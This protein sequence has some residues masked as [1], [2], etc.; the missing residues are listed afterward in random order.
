ME[1]RTWRVRARA[2]RLGRRSI[3]AEARMGHP[4]LAS[5]R[6]IRRFSRTLAHAPTATRTMTGPALLHALLLQITPSLFALPLKI[7]PGNLDF[8]FHLNS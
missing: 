6:H 3:A 4:A 5:Q 8:A 1:N 7:T 2:R